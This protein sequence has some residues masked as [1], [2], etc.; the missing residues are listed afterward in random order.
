MPVQSNFTPCRVLLQLLQ[1]QRALGHLWKVQLLTHHCMACMH[2]DV[3]KHRHIL[4][5]PKWRWSIHR[6]VKP[7][8]PLQDGRTDTASVAQEG[9]KKRDNLTEGCE[10]RCKTKA[11]L[12]VYVQ[13]NKLFARQLGCRQRA[14]HSRGIS[15]DHSGE[16]YITYEAN[17]F[18]AFSLLTCI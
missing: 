14:S 10:G 16:R 7:I 1:L 9:I 11:K 5:M 4:L 15:H 17:I 2:T 8:H 6:M 13:V 18:R 3:Q 12:D